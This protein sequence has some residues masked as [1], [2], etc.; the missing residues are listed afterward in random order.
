MQ[1]EFLQAAKFPNPAA[2][3]EDEKELFF[4]KGVHEVPEHVVQ[5][6]YFQA[7]LK[8][9]KVVEPEAAKQSLAESINERNAR[10]AAAALQK[11]AAAKKPAQVQAK[12]K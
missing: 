9:K 5:H 2:T 1:V 6:P 8:D 3:K 7:L 12:G 4:K 10:L 11:P